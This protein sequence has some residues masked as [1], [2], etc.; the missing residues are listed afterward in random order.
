MLE[1]H[2]TA[3]WLCIACPLTL[4]TVTAFVLFVREAMRPPT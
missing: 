4:V 3:V 1:H 2:F